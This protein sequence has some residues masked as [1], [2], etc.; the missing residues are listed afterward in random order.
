MLFV[1]AR[2]ARQAAAEGGRRAARGAV[3]RCRGLRLVLVPSHS[4]HHYHL[5]RRFQ[6]HRTLYYYGI[7]FANKQLNV[8]L[9]LII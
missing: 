4:R 7:R 5:L 2:I 1:G 6:C 9:R 8:G 3:G